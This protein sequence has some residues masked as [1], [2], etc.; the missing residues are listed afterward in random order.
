M[1]WRTLHDEIKAFQP[2]VVGCGENHALYT[3][4]ALKFFEMVK[5]AAPEAK[6]VA[7]GG[8]FSNMAHRYA[9]RS[10]IDAICIGE[11]EITFAELIEA[12][13]E[14][15]PDL[16]KVDGIA[17]GADDQVVKTAP[18][19]LVKDLDSLPIP[20]YD[21]LPMHLYGRSR[22]LFSP[23]GAT[24]HHSAAARASAVLRLVDNHG[25][26]Q[27]RQ[28]RQHSLVA[29]LADKSVDRV[30]E[31]GVAVLPVRKRG[32]VWVD[33]SWNTIPASTNSSPTG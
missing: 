8:H 21:L 12:F 25:R 11:G 6:T 1:G 29:A 3:N 32:F 13:A 16:S 4:E 2:H 22:Y 18:R 26:S 17:F 5:S 7:G 14:D 28:R 33:E 10:D 9:T 15:D 31:D 30:M 27:G 19:K 24:M 23:S 20:A